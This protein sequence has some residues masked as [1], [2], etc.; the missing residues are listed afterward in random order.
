MWYSESSGSW[1]KKGNLIYLTSF[2]QRDK[3]PIEY[4]KTK[5]NQRKSIVK[6]KINILEKPE[7]DYICFTYINGK[8]LLDERSLL[9][10]HVQGSY[11]FDTK[12]PVDSL[13]F[14]VAKRPFVLRGTGYAMCYDDIRTETIHPHLSIGETLDVTV[15]IIDSLFGYKVFKDKKIELKNRKIIFRDKG[16]KNKLYLKQ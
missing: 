1:R 8:P 12:V 11:S 16:R 3:I 14:L 13:Y 15:N 2:E 4:V 5:N 9:E 7:T 10:P 6:I